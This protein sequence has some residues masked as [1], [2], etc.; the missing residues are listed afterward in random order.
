M[1]KIML[2]G[3]LTGTPEIRYSQSQD[4]VKTARYSIAVNK[5]KPRTDG[6]TADF[7]KIV[8]FGRLAD[9]SEKY[10]AKGSKVLVT[11]RVQTGS[12]ERNGIK[13]PF[14]EVIACEIEFAESR[15]T[16]RDAKKVYVKNG[17]SG[18]VDTDD[19]EIYEMPFN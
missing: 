19:A 1:N 9:L 4:P 13:V 2:M 18:F 17:D 14:F 15:S 6:V 3:R 12:Y 7:F 11:G 16:A 8:A 5:L 10:L